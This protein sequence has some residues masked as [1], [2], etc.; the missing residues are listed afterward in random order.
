[1]AGLRSLDGPRCWELGCLAALRLGFA[2]TICFGR[3]RQ[4]NAPVYAG[5][6][7]ESGWC[8]DLASVQGAWGQAGARYSLGGVVAFLIPPLSFPFG[9]ILFFVCLFVC[10]FVRSFACFVC[11]PIGF[12]FVFASF[13]H[14]FVH[15]FFC[16]YLAK[17]DTCS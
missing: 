17:A 5:C 16:F 13:A 14:P 7:R 2:P 10:S 15:F 11:L 12:V 8:Q 3:A 4:G 1:M 9:S 6:L